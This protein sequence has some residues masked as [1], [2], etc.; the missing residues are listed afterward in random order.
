GTARLDDVVAAELQDVADHRADVGVVVYQQ[1]GRHRFRGPSPRVARP[2][3]RGRPRA[4]GR[5]RWEESQS[6]CHA[7]GRD[8][9]A[10]CGW[11]PPRSRPMA[12]APP[13]DRGSRS[14][15]VVSRG[16][17][18]A[19]LFVDA[20]EEGQEGPVEAVGLLDEEAVAAG[21]DLEAGAGDQ[22]GEP[23]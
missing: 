6:P 17:R 16:E 2:S 14:P 15:P 8:K 20:R 4:G 12:A 3:S 5:A 9:W 23:A 10:K 19:R 22:G 18:L 13:T 7:G 21:D 1:D 11:A